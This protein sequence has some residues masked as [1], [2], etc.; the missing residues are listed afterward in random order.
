MIRYSNNDYRTPRQ[1]GMQTNGMARQPMRQMGQN[2][3]K[4]NS[5]P[6][7]KKYDCTGAPINGCSTLIPESCGGTPSLAAVYSPKQSFTGLY[8]PSE[9]LSRGTLFRALDLPLKGGMGQ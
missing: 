1:R 9:A 2:T 3:A 6:A 4:V 5:E 7:E 8:Q